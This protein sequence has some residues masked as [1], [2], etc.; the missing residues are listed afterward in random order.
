MTID[1][2]NNYLFSLPFSLPPSLPPFFLSLYPP[3][4]PP[5]L[6]CI[7]FVDDHIASSR[8]LRNTRDT[9]GNT[10]SVSSPPYIEILRGRD[11]RDGLPGPAGRDGKDG[12]KGLNVG[13]G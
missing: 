10:T 1:I 11:G 2:G 4:P 13:Q 5:V 6:L 12:E 9:G 3:P 8:E 7:I